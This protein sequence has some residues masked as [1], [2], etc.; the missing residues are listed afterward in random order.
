MAPP[1][2]SPVSTVKLG[3]TDAESSKLSPK[4]S[5]VQEGGADRCPYPSMD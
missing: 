4:R 1:K 3:G 5:T 2:R